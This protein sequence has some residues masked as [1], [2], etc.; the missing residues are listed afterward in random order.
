MPNGIRPRWDGARLWWVGQPIRSFDRL[1]TRQAPLLAAF[2]LRG[3]P[4]E[5]IP[6]PFPPQ[7]DDG[8]EDA[9]RRLRVTVQ[10]LNRELPAGTIRFRDNGTQVWWEPARARARSGHR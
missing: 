5:P 10:N 3:W 6:D 4:V 2:E 7:P 9:R 1:P 8:P